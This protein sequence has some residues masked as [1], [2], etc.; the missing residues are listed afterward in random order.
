MKLPYRSN[1]MDAVV[2]CEVLEHLNFN[3]LPVL[4]EINRVLKDNGI[5]YIG[6]PNQASLGNCLL[7]L[8]GKSIHNSISDFFLN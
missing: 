2:M 8:F 7:L 1:S 3:P 6:M 4:L 5:I